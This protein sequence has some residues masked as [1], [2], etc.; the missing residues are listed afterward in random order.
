MPSAIEPPSTSLQMR[1]SV[2]QDNINQ[3]HLAVLHCTASLLIGLVG[4]GYATDGAAVVEQRGAGEPTTVTQ[5]PEPADAFRDASRDP[6][7]DAQHD[8]R[9]DTRL[10]ATADAQGRVSANR[11]QRRLVVFSAEKQTPFNLFSGVYDTDAQ[12]SIGFRDE[13]DV[14]AWEGSRNYVGFW[15][16]PPLDLSELERIELQMKGQVGGRACIDL[17]IEDIVPGKETGHVYR[18][19]CLELT[20]ELQTHVLTADDFGPF[21]YFG[22][23]QGE[24]DW[25]RVKNVEVQIGTRSED[26]FPYYGTYRDQEEGRITRLETEATAA[27]YGHFC[28]FGFAFDKPIDL[29]DLKAVQ[30]KLQGKGRVD[31][32]LIDR[33]RVSYYKRGLRLDKRARTYQLAREDFKLF[34]YNAIGVL[35]WS[36]IRNVQ[37]QVS[38][39]AGARVAV[40]QL[41]I[42]LGDGSRYTIGHRDNGDSYVALRAVHVVVRDARSKITER[43]RLASGASGGSPPEARS[44]DLVAGGAEGPANAAERGR[45]G[46]RVIRATSR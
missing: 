26:Y 46:S 11:S 18:S 44:V 45:V 39:R 16:Q 15:H 5:G 8:Q 31:L 13:P 4:F 20:D 24:F 27:W 22:E 42:E 9:A 12:G 3:R 33:N 35:D 23:Q 32:H 10:D 17:R 34:P 29:S 1:P 30:A 43:Q 37:F 14:L 28:Y 2:K 40:D 21:A 7:R 6:F 25:S 19:D 36:N 41:G 38:T